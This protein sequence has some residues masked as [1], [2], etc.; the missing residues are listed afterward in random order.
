[1]GNYKPEFR[2]IRRYEWYNGTGTLRNGKPYG[3]RL[4]F[5]HSGPDVLTE[6][7]SP[8]NNPGDWTINIFWHPLIADVSKLLLIQLILSVCISEDF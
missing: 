5:K 8:K 1:M 2:G 7:P 3:N 6:C 4:T